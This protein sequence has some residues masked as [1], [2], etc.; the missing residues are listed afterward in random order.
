MIRWELARWGRFARVVAVFF[1]EVSS[2]R[3]AAEL[4]WLVGATLQNRCSR[5]PKEWAPHGEVEAMNTLMTGVVGLRGGA[6]RAPHTGAPRE[7]RRA[8]P[9]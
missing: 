6:S 7:A 4:M 3:C 8:H 9:E 2:K 5:G 1:D